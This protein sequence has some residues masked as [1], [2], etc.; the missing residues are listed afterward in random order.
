MARPSRRGFGPDFIHA[1]TAATKLAIGVVAGSVLFALTKGS[2]G[3]LLLLVPDLVLHQFF[4]WQPVTYA[5][6]GSSPME[7]I[8][9]A[10]IVWQIG[11][12]LEASWRPR[13]MLWFS[14]GTT[15]LAA[16]FTVLLAAGV[17]KLQSGVF[18]GVFALSSCLWVAYGLS[19]GRQETN[20]WGMPLSGNTF[21]LIGAGFVLLSGAYYGWLSVLPDLIAL[22]LTTFFLKVGTPRL[23]WLRFTSWRLQRQLKGRSRHLKVVGKDRNIGGGSDNYLH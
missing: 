15:V 20:F 1:D 5:F 3:P 19:F 10:L 14:L 21:A 18:S 12:S 13:R 8:F 17:P 2:F 6:I 7:V 4:L 9:G 23:L 22:A 11:N 16:L